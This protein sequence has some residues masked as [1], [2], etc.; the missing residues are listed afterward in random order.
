MRKIITKESE[1]K[2][3]KRN[4]LIIGI[5]LVVVMGLSTIGYSLSGVSKTGDSSSS[6]IYNNIQFTKTSGL[7]Y[8]KP[9]ELTF[10]FTYNPN[11]VEKTSNILN[12]ISSYSGKP[13]YI[14]SK[15]SNAITEIYRNLVYSNNIVLRMQ[16]ACPENENCNEDIPIKNCENNFIIIREANES[17]ITQNNKCVFI[18]GKSEDLVKQTDSFLYKITGIQ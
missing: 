4:Q 7:W 2:R 16:E 11:E 6:I 15:N 1:A 3:R 5:I 12:E 14:Y 13:L 17:R 8:A 9:N 10:S 18:E